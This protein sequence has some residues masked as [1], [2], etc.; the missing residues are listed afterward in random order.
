VKKVRRLTVGG[1]FGREKRWGRGAVTR[2]RKGSTQKKKSKEK[3][4]RRHR[5]GG[6]GEGRCGDEGVGRTA[7]K[8]KRKR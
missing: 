7:E 8:K 3:E 1:L 2:G 6:E 4:T 5:K